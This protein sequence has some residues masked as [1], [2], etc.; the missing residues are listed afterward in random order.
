MTDHPSQAPSPR[1]LH[2]LD[3]LR[4]F[5]AV[6]VVLYHYTAWFGH[7]GD[8]HVA[9]G[10]SAV[11]G[12]GHFG[13]EL[14]F[15]ISGFVIFMTLD[16][17][18]SLRAF[19]V[20]RVLRLYPGFLACMA[21]TLL[22]TAALDPAP[23]SPGRL[24]A[25]LT[26]APELF[27]TRP[28]DGSYWS[29]LYEFVFYA[30]AALCCLVLGCRRPEIPCAIWLAAA[31]TIRL[32][33]LN[34]ACKPLEQ[35]TAA[36]FAHLFIIGIMLF[37]IHAGRATVLTWLLLLLALE[38]AL[39]GPH[40]VFQPTPRIVYG[41][42]ILGFAGLVWFAATP[43]G[44]ALAVRPL[45]VLGQISYP[46]YL[47][48]QAAGFLVIAR[49]EAAGFTADAAI[50]TAILLSVGVAWVIHRGVERP[51]QRRGKAALFRRQPATF[52]VSAV[53]PRP[54]ASQQAGASGS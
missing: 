13:V 45:R 37:R 35:L 3:A 31:L 46:L 23:L 27:G 18:E 29:L 40:F 30:L 4:G 52:T 39:F 10:P 24:L 17:T 36:W 5:A 34:L 19:I 41:G 1:R 32:S 20:A 21:V 33:G 42:I 8:P 43:A 2:G 54:S 53:F 48:H 44:C 38:T 15:V 6:A 49:L 11:F 16:R 22:V 51:A 9:P 26:M 7:D 47:V 28:I 14:F 50:G 25:N 12:R